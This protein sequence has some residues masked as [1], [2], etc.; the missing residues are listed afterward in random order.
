MLIF[1]NYFI[2]YPPTTLSDHP[3]NIDSG[4]YYA[5]DDKDYFYTRGHDPMMG[6]DVMITTSKKRSDSKLNKNYKGYAVGIIYSYLEKY[7]PDYTPE[8]K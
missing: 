1:G 8:D 2:F 6:N 3:G 5:Y 7:D 4:G